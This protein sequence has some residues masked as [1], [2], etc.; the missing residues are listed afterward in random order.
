MD[1]AFKMGKTLASKG[2]CGMFSAD[3]MVVMNES[4]AEIFLIE[5]N[6]RKGGTTHPYQ[7]ALRITKSSFDHFSGYLIDESKNRI[8]YIS[9]DNVVNS[10]LRNIKVESF[11]EAAAKANLLFDSGTNSGVIFHML[12]AMPDFGKLGYTIIARSDQKIALLE[13]SLQ[14]FFKSL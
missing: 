13:K 4:N 7:T 2:I 11:L 14:S 6:L 12:Q 5:I 8:R 9:N 10:K 3:F 1:Y